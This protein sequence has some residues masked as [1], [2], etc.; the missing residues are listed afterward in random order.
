MLTCPAAPRR[1][2]PQVASL[3]YASQLQYAGFVHRLSR[4]GKVAHR[5]LAVDLALSLLLDLPAPFA[6]DAGYV[7]TAGTPGAGDS[8]AAPA[9][10]SAVCL[11]VLAKRGGDKA[12]GVRARALSNLAELVA[13]FGALLA[14]DPESSQYAIAAHFVRALVASQQLAVTGGGA[15][16]APLA[17]ARECVR[18][19]WL[20][21]LSAPGKP[22]RD[23]ACFMAGALAGMLCT[24]HCHRQGC[25]LC[26]NS[27]AL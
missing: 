10:W 25:G 7:G 27:T 23:C 11:A 8:G 3:P 26:T 1:P 24:C 15:C 9:P 5:S 16:G 18:K 13:N 2:A 17:V 21:L 19:R 4:T 6:A 20:L 14:Q 12:P 22:V